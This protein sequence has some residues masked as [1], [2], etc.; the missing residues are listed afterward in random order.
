MTA[1]P[2]AVIPIAMTPQPGSA[3]NEPARSIVSRIKRRLS[4]A[5]SSSATGRGCK[6]SGGMLTAY[7]PV[8]WF[9][10]T[11]CRKVSMSSPSSYFLM[12]NFNDLPSGCEESFLTRCRRN[13]WPEDE[14]FRRSNGCPI[15]C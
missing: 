10:S 13:V 6:R 7:H 15:V 2:I 11:L 5:R 12:A 8:T 14:D 4:R 1:A 3:V 9:S